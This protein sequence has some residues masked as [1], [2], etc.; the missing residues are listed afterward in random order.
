MYLRRLLVAA[1]STLFPAMATAAAAPVTLEA[2]LSQ[3][4]IPRGERT[5]VYLRVGLK[6]E[7]I[8]STRDRAPLN[9]ALVIDRSGSMSGRKMDEARRAAMMAVD[10]LGERDIISVV[11]YDDRVEVEVPATRAG[12]GRDIKRRI[13]G[14]SARGSTAIHAGLLA[15]ANEVRKFKSRDYVNR[16][17]LLSDGLANVGPR[18]PSDFESLGRELGTEGIVVS[19]IGLGLGYNEDLMTRLARASDG[20]HAFVQE[21]QDLATFF[22]KE[23]DDAENIVAQDVEIIIECEEGVVPMKSLGRAARIEGNRI[24]YKVGQL[25]GG[26]EQVLLAEVETPELLGDKPASIANVRVVYRSAVN[27]RPETVQANVEARI[28]TDKDEAKSSYRNEVIR[29]ATLLEARARK[30]EAIRLRDA[31]RLEEAKRKFQANAAEISAQQALY[32]MAPSPELQAE[33]EANVKASEIDDRDS[34]SWNLQRK[35]MRQQNS[36]VSGGKT[37]Y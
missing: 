11:S 12:S 9:V 5:R 16:I 14:L 3:S 27:D 4:A 2:T 13:R 24:V 23:F 1:V 20:N 32:G 21:P 17:I 33:R 15:G 22:N 37:R 7:R 29:D 28:A 25:I 6:S 10:R 8:R 34:A 26:S 30:D 19:T 36:N 35:E 31:G 18:K